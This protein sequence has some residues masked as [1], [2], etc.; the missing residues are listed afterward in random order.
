MKDSQEKIQ[1]IQMMEQNIQALAQQKQQVQTQS[2][3]IESALNEIE[4][5]KESYKIVANIMIKTSKEK[6]QKDLNQ[7]KEVLNIR[8][9]TLEK[10]ENKLK[11][12]IKELQK[13]VI[14]EKK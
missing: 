4:D 11:D 13:E 10:Q 6:I 5:S 9:Q 14:S 12:A 2:F 8:M 1:K 7:K 3:E